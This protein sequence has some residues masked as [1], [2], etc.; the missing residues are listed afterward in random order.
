MTK[1]NEKP[2]AKYRSTMYWRA[3]RT[4]RSRRDYGATEDEIREDNPGWSCSGFTARWK[5][6]IDKGLIVRP[7]KP[8]TRKG[9]SGRQQQIMYAPEYAPQLL[10]KESFENDR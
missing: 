7:G 10:N 2:S 9:R 8:W 5:E 4:I 1:H 6:M 3:M